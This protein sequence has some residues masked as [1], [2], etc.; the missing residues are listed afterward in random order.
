M[1]KLTAKGKL[2][3]RSIISIVFAVFFV[4]MNLA[5]ILQIEGEETVAAFSPFSYF[6]GEA[7]TSDVVQNIN[8][9]ADDVSLKE[10]GASFSERFSIISLIFSSEMGLF[11]C[12]CF[13]V[14]AFSTVIS[15]H[16]IR[17]IVGKEDGRWGAIFQHSNSV[18]VIL[19]LEGG[20]VQPLIAFCLLSERINYAKV[21]YEISY[22]PIV[23]M[24]AAYILVEGLIA[25][26]EVSIVSDLYKQNVWD[27]QAVKEMPIFVGANASAGATSGSVEVVADSKK[28]RYTSHLL[29]GL[30]F[31]IC[32]LPHKGE[33]SFLLRVLGDTDDLVYSLIFSL[34]LTACAVVIQ[35]L[36]VFLSCK[37]EKKKAIEKI[38]L[39]ML[40]S[41]LIMSIFSFFEVSC[42]IRYVDWSIFVLLNL[43][44]VVCYL[45]AYVRFYILDIVRMRADIATDSPSAPQSA[46]A[47]EPAHTEHRP[48]TDEERTDESKD[49]IVIFSKSGVD[50]DK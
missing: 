41:L 10:N 26:L 47:A 2:V 34:A 18:I 32:F 25:V 19:I 30:A 6:F 17:K 35:R 46:A 48:E 42:S 43:A 29:A 45:I 39:R 7:K 3:C 27:I 40:P 9:C 5:P 12:L 36:I 8:E 20:W 4:I 15:R 28:V 21:P 31:I 24:F 14:G 33:K 37:K 16:K 49:D 1:K 22:M 50:D 11:G 38:W 23:W 44:V 13:I